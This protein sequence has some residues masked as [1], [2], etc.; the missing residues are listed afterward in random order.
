MFE[1]FPVGIL[2]RRRVAIKFQQNSVLCVICRNS[3]RQLAN[4][5]PRAGKPVA[6]INLGSTRADAEVTLKLERPCGKAL[7]GLVQRPMI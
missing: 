5:R 6:A 2:A 7:V 4:C 1:Q 3:G